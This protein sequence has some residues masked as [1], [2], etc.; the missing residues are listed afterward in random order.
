MRFDLEERLF[1]GYF[2]FL[3]GLDLVEHL[4]NMQPPINQLAK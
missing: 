3:I 1:A 2:A 4:P